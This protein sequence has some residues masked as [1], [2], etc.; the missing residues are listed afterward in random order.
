MSLFP[1][2]Y[3]RPLET[4]AARRFTSSTVGT[5]MHCIASTYSRPFLLS[6]HVQMCVFLIKLGI[7]MSHYASVHRLGA[8]RHFFPCCQEE[9]STIPS[10]GT[11]RP[12]FVPSVFESMAWSLVPPHCHRRSMLHSTQWSYF[13]LLGSHHIES[14]R[15]R[16][17]VLLLWAELVF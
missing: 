10:R 17:D 5:E 4:C 8:G 14:D 16:P 3:R 7:K 12:G 11:F 2:C 15:P 1:F 6:R 13:S 9:T